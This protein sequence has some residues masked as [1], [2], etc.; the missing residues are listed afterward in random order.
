MR[1]GF[2]IKVKCDNPY[3]ET[4]KEHN[5]TSI[6]LYG[7]GQFDFLIMVKNG[8]TCRSCSRPA[9]PI[10]CGFTKCRWFVEC[11]QQGRGTK[12]VKKEGHM[13]AN[14]LIEY[15]DVRVNNWEYLR[16]VVIPAI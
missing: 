5:G 4:Q 7:Y 13:P 8:F 12:D 10:T 2:C 14:K 9:S 1:P 16:F 6:N 15:D 11:K 3:C